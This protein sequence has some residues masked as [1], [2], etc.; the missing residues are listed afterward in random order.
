MITFEKNAL[1]RTITCR[2]GAVDPQHR[3]TLGLLGAMLLEKVGRAIGAELA[4]YFQRC[5]R[6]I[7]KCSPSACA[8]R[9]SES[10]PPSIGI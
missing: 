3:G 2:L 7:S 8:T 1:S 4:Y 5:N 9:W 6:S 10:C